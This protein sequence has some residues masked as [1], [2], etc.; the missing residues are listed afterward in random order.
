MQ[1]LISYQRRY[2]TSPTNAREYNFLLGEYWNWSK[3]P[4]HQEHWCY[5][6]WG[7]IIFRINSYLSP[8]PHGIIQF[9]DKSKSGGFG[10]YKERYEIGLGPSTKSTNASRQGH[11]KAI[12]I[13][14]QSVLES[15]P[16]PVQNKERG[17]DQIRIDCKSKAMKIPHSQDQ[18]KLSP[19]HPFLYLNITST[20]HSPLLPI[21]CH[22]T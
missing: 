11:M 9:V 14:R 1:G 4:L 21:Y 6:D 22:I 5:W 8:R 18:K 19:F 10:S 12:R 13:E 3:R 15:I 2:E 17:M 20:K 16:T 7:V